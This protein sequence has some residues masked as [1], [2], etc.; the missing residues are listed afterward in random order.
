MKSGFP[1]LDLRDALLLVLD[2][3]DY[4]HRACTITE[5]VGAVLPVNVIEIARAAIAA[6]DKAAAH[7][8]D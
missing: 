1:K 6:H 7:S 3:V 5:A 2:H 8:Q 4:M